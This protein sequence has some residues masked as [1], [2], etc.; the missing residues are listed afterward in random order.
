MKKKLQT[1][2]L[3]LSNKIVK[4]LSHVMNFRKTFDFFKR[5]SR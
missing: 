5:K 2:C 1:N 3:W 4:N